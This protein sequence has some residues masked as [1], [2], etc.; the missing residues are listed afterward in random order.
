MPKRTDIKSILIIGAGPI[1]IGQACEFDYSG[2]QACKA[3]REEN[4]RVILVNSN[5]ATIMTDPEMA[6]AIYIEPIT[7]QMVEKIIALELPDAILPTMGGQ[8]ALNCALD[9][10]KHGVLERYGVELIG[11][12]REAIDKAEDREKFKQAM[13]RIGLESARSTIAH[14]LEEALQVQAMVGY[15]AIIRPSFTMGGS[16][17]GIAY[18]REEFV[19]ICEHGLEISPTNELL[20]EES[21]IGWKEF[22]MEVVRDRLDNCIIVCAIEN[23]DPMGIH[24]G[25]SITVAPTQTL[26]DKEYQIMRNASI[27]VLREIGVETGGS[28]V[29]FAIN[30]QDGRMLIIEMNPRVSR[31]SAL[32]SKA[33][34]FPIAKVASKLAIG[35]TLDELRNDITSGVTPISFEPT[36]DYVVT[37]IPRFA[38]EKF[39]QANDRLT[40]QM[41]SV[42]EVMAIGRTFQESF[43]KALRGLEIGVDG[44]DEK[45][46]DIEIIK[47]E[48]SDP[49]PERIWYIADAF[50][51]GIKLNEIH[52]LTHIDPWFLGQIEDLVKQEE[53]LSGECIDTLNLN[54]LFKLK[55]SGFSDRRLAKLLNTGQ[56]AVRTRRHQFNLHPVYKR[57]DTCAAEFV[58]R[59]AYM[60]STY[61]EECEALPTNRKKIMVLGG[62]PNR[63]GQGIEF[64]YCCVHAA[65]AL[66][67]SGFE[68]IMVNCNPE[69]VSTDY[70][71]SDRL[72]F[73]PL[74]LEDVLEIVA[75]EKPLGI[76]VQYGG[77]TPLK[78]ARDLEKNG[79]PII[80]TS[81][82]MIDCAENRERFQ[83]MLHQLGLKQPVNR[84]ARDPLLALIAADEIGYPLVVR[85]SYVLG[86]RAM[87]IVH[88]KRDLE[89]Y[90]REAV[91]IS[92]DSPVLLDRFL[93][94][95]TEVDVDAICD[96]VSVVIGGIMEHI[97]QAGVHSGDSACSLPSFSLSRAIKNELIRQTKAMAQALHVVGLMNV[98]FAIKD[99][100]I[101]VLEVN[102]RASRTVPFVSKAT[103]LQ[104]AKVAARC[105]VGVTLASQ[106]VIEEI[107]P[108]YYSIKEAVFPFIKFPG[109]DTILG[110]EMKSTGEVMGVG[111]TF[112]EA[113]VKSQLAAGVKLP[114]T[115]NI[116]I[117]VRHSDKL[118]IV[119]IA[120]NLVELQFTLYAT[121]GTA[122]ALTAA[123]L[124]VITVNKVTEGRPHI[125]DMIK[126]N[127]IN[128]IINTVEDKRS[129]IQ[130][131]YSIRHAALQS[132]VTYYTT[133]AGARAAC[134]GMVGMRE[135][136]AYDL[137]ELHTRL[138]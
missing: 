136:R 69:T 137:Q 3:L 84:T 48:L 33:T 37:K 138:N 130:D 44:L 25:D 31:S 124:A 54:S 21:L 74:T 76:I 18:N 110:P 90:M 30:P 42:G 100:I 133:L 4:Y 108:P 82:D 101:Y 98:Q 29:Q 126:N 68:T 9:L 60:Y 47:K 46:T 17:G 40:T 7:W 115:G 91:K 106:N 52:D 58:T 120:R 99:E 70:D 105:M 111:D 131:S 61:E 67:E 80:G 32:A 5:P 12:S 95:A 94:D 127:E 104:L 45:T 128:L 55:R 8:T 135:L 119:E 20:I 56:T 65:I 41:K 75:I 38:F 16:G 34:G 2:T 102:P 113:F 116:F 1:V 97:E 35:Y 92:H 27:A 125:V 73:E 83:K 71:T 78:L 114:T 72:Y 51:C 132:R 50:R 63:I 93:N 64:D 62:G 112:A 85:P 87:E 81:P 24:T 77:Q 86:G 122:A 22:E 88:E 118:S 43:Q 96:G 10:A 107:I 109:V 36:I 79:A 103:G 23:I 121:R 6:D 59:T 19:S 28:N 134:I 26:T 13:T 117:S 66:R 49:G 53:T 129:A 14:S 11:A 57:V 39:P 123:G 15:P 89:R